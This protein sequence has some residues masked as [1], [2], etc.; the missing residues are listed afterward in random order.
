MIT[1]LSFRAVREAVAIRY[2]ALFRPD[3]GAKSAWLVLERLGH[4]ILAS[5]AAGSKL[6]Q[7]VDKNY[8]DRWHHRYDDA[9]RSGESPSLQH[10][11][12][13]ACYLQCTFAYRQESAVQS[14]EGA[15][16]DS[17]V[18]IYNNYVI[19]IRDHLGDETLRVFG[20]TRGQATKP[21]YKKLSSD[22][23]PDDDEFE[24]DKDYWVIAAK[25][26]KGEEEW[27]PAFSALGTVRDICRELDNKSLADIARGFTYFSE[28]GIDNL[29][30]LL[31]FE[32]LGDFLHLLSEAER[33]SVGRSFAQ[34]RLFINPKRADAVIVE[35]EKFLAHLMVHPKAQKAVRALGLNE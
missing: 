20:P 7:Y 17:I 12:V 6:P 13:M 15:L 29:S 18:D 5:A 19:S 8:F 22:L 35:F 28:K 33:E 2:P 25:G 34:S 26:D 32:W 24:P 30:S 23:D 16:V 10:A 21:Q 27:E 11:V 9:A 1:F 4:A 14:P 31:D 3:D